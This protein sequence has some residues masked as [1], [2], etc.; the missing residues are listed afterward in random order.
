MHALE[1]GSRWSLDWV[2][3]LEITG[4]QRLDWMHALEI[5]SRWR[6]NWMH[7][8]ENVSQRLCVVI[9]AVQSV[10]KRLKQGEGVSSGFRRHER[11][12]GWLDDQQCPCC[13]TLCRNPASAILFA[14]PAKLKRT[15]K[16]KLIVHRLGGVRR[17]SQICDECRNA[18]NA[19]MCRLPESL[20]RWVRIVRRE[21]SARRSACTH[22]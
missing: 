4:D 19:R 21:D 13:N 5:G 14:Q 11:E 8:L 20:Q 9:S 18:R 15:K 1:I 6:L 3:A 17:C 10:T 16:C 2:H 22:C 7:A 12:T